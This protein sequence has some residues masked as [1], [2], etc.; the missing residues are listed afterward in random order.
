MGELVQHTIDH[1]DAA[2]E[3]IQAVPSEE[4]GILTFLLGSFLPAIATL[5][6]AAAGN[7]FHPKIDREKMTE[8]FNLITGHA[9]DHERITQW[10]ANHRQWTLDRLPKRDQ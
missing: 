9:S 1:L 4:T 5:E 10:Y 3:Y 8:I 7:E 6:V 2:L